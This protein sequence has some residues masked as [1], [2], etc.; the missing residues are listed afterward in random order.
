[1]TAIQRLVNL[2][3]SDPGFYVV[4]LSAYMETLLNNETRSLPEYR[5]LSFRDKVE[6]VKSRLTENSREYIPEIQALNGIKN[7]RA[8]T[9]KVRHEFKALSQAE[10]KAATHRFVQ[11]CQVLGCATDGQLE[12]LSETLQQWHDRLNLKEELEELKTMKWEAFKAQRDN[13]KLTEELEELR[14]IQQ[15]KVELEE[16]LKLT[17][18]NLALL[19]K[20]GLKT[21]EKNKSLREERQALKMKI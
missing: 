14:L 4:A 3:A 5:E 16:D 10:A 21:A 6:I 15:E 12:L 20:K 17:N 11:V 18:T 8:L 13:R 2:S 9:N 19:A 7:D 1:M